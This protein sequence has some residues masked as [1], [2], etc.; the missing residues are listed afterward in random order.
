MNPRSSKVNISLDGRLDLTRNKVDISQFTDFDE[1]NS[2]IY[3]N[4]LSPLYS[5]KVAN[6]NYAVFN[7]K[8]DK[9]TYINN[10]LYKNDV[11]VMKTKGNGYFSIKEVEEPKYWDTYDIWNGHVAKS[12]YEFGI[13]HYWYDDTEYTWQASSAANATIACRTRIIDGVPITAYVFATPTK[14][15]YQFVYLSRNTTQAYLGN[16][17][18][19]QITTNQI[20]SPTTAGS[21]T[22]YQNR[23]AAIT[24]ST[25]TLSDNDKGFLNPLIQIANPLTNVYVVSFISNSGGKIDPL[26]DLRYF[27]ILNNNGTFYNHFTA[28]PYPASIVEIPHEQ[29]V[30]IITTP[31][32][33]R[34]NNNGTCYKYMIPSGNAEWDAAHQA[35]VGKYFSRVGQGNVLL[36]PIEFD[37]GYEPVW[38]Y[39]TQ[40]NDG[41][42]TLYSSYSYA[43]HN[44]VLTIT[45]TPNGMAAGDVAVVSMT[46]TPKK[47]VHTYNEQTRFPSPTILPNHEYNVYTDGSMALWESDGNGG[48]QPV[49]KKKLIPNSGVDKEKYVINDKD[50]YQYRPL[51]NADYQVGSYFS[52]SSYYVYLSSGA[53]NDQEY[54]ACQEPNRNIRRNIH[55]DVDKDGNP[56][57]PGAILPYDD[58]PVMFTNQQAYHEATIGET[59]NGVLI[60]TDEDTYELDVNN[61]KIQADV[62]YWMQINGTDPLYVPLTYED[63]PDPDTGDYAN[64][65]QTFT[66]MA[67]RAET[68]INLASRLYRKYYALNPVTAWVDDSPRT[69]T[70][71]I[72]NSQAFTWGFR[73]DHNNVD[74]ESSTLWGG[75]GVNITVVYTINGQSAVTKTYGPLNPTGGPVQFTNIYTWTTQQ[76]ATQCMLPNIM[77]DNGMMVYA[78]GIVNRAVF[79][80]ANILSFAGRTDQMTSG[81]TFRFI[82]TGYYDL[83][84]ASVP[85][86]VLATTIDIGPNYYRSVLSMSNGTNSTA[87]TVEGMQILYDITGGTFCNAGGLSADTTYGSGWFSAKFYNVQGS[88]AK[89]ENGTKWRYL[90]NSAGL[91][92]GLSFGEDDY[93][94]TLLTEW[95]SIAEDKYV[96][97]D[98][99]HLGWKSTDGKWYEITNHE[100][101]HNAN[102]SIIFDRYIIV[103]TNGFWNAYDINRSQPLHYATDFNNR[104]M[105]GVNNLKYSNYVALGRTN[106]VGYMLSKMFVSGQNALY[107]VSNVALT[108]I[109][110]S[111][112]AY[113]NICTGYETLIWGQS[114]NEYLPQYIEIFAGINTDATTA[115]YQYSIIEYASTAVILKDASLVGLNSPVA[116]QAAT[117]YSPNIFSQF[118]KTYSNRD[119]IKNGSYCYPIAYNETT[120]VLSYSSGKQLSNVDA[121]FVIQSQFYALIDGKICSVVYDDYSIIGLEAIIDITGMTYIGTLPTKAYFWSQA[122]RSLYSFTGDANLSLEFEANKISTI[123]GT[124]YSTLKEAIFIATDAGTIVL[125]DVQQYKIDTSEVTNIWF[126]NDGYFIVEDSDNRLTYYSYEKDN[127]PVGENETVEKIPVKVETKF[128]GPANGQVVTIDKVSVMFRSDEREPGT[129]K[130]NSS[131]MTDIGYK[132]EEKKYNIK[133]EDI[134]KLT[135]SFVVNFTPKAARGQG[136]KFFIESPYP[137]VRITESIT[138]MVENTSTKHNV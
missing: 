74:V 78:G 127:I 64:V 18:R 1:K 114:D 69:F 84:A 15:V 79:P 104:A 72:S 22:F 73:Y 62:D 125:T 29:T 86:T 42:Y 23:G 120:P 98:G 35:D 111:P 51:W 27:N 97:F 91:M 17:V 63:V 46:Y 119:M 11:E 83:G 59:W 126:A 13:V 76:A 122:N 65:P 31:T 109:Q 80:V 118:I 26:N 9:F 36:D 44:D 71:T 92:S 34:E 102:I 28:S 60:E 37:E 4:T 138:E 3:G 112:Q 53:A 75:F 7:S 49:Y 56:I 40:S 67:N 70:S 12:K 19:Q 30:S 132:A 93:I 108:S 82:S 57:T 33:T 85:G 99:N 39:D 50:S 106:T 117:Y 41:T 124:Y 16:T 81:D 130:F 77:L 134:D 88:I 136:F 103:P 21:G 128:Y 94:G 129:V 68:T 95:N 45:N 131:T 55:S 8:G 89:M 96:Y 90:Y 58:Y 107:E 133:S 2:P 110:I 113:I 121:V 105:A 43:E 48:Y 66:S 25:Q 116:I 100:N 115:E 32:V 20:L 135:D 6:E 47:K 137:I 54:R 14:N 10:I 123:Y 24:A 52:S 5:K 101:E 87:G 61:H 38:S